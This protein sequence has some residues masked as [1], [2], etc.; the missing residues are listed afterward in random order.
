MISCPLLLLPPPLQV[1]YEEKA[2]TKSKRLCLSQR[3]WQPLITSLW[4]VDETTGSQDAS[5]A[6]Q[7]ERKGLVDLGR[8]GHKWG[9]HVGDL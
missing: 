6:Q 2:L 3:F 8:V 5:K 4:K 1:R 7:E 9:D